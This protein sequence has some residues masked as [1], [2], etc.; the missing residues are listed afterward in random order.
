METPW[1]EPLGGSSLEE[2]QKKK[3]LQFETMQMETPYWNT[4]L[5]QGANISE[6]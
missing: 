6:K 4:L 2:N 3:T 5:F 1:M